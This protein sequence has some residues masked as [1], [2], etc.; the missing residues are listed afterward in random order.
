M[1]SKFQNKYR[2]PSARATFHDYNG[3]AYFVTICTKHHAHFF[4]EIVHT[5]VE[6]VRAPSLQDEPQMQFTATGN[7]ANENLRDITV[8]YPYAEI[9]LWVV[10][11]NHIHAIVFID[12]DIAICRDGARTVSP[13]NAT[14]SGGSRTVS[15]ENATQSDGARTVSHANAISQSDG[16]RTVSTERWKNEIVNEKMQEISRHKKSL[17]VAIGGFK[18][19]VT[20][21]AHENDMDFAWQTRFHDRIIRDQKEMNLIAEY[22][23][24]NAARWDMDC[25]N[26]PEN[27]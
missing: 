22:I 10:M 27:P 23:E 9:P 16:A 20:K 3:G 8:H 13:A 25:Y 1:D 7:F 5:P 15:H 19:A 26:K 14:Q 12:G 18:S 4:G 6:T 24:H 2:I 17:S 11:P 21:F